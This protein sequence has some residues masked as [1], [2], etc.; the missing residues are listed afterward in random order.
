MPFAIIRLVDP[1]RYFGAIIEAVALLRTNWRIALMMARR[2]LTSRHANQVIGPFW[3]IGH[4]LFQ[5]LIF[6]FL[7]GVVFKQQLG[8]NFYDMPRDYTIYILSGLVA[9]LSILPVLT[10]SC[11]SVTS[12]AALVK[13]FKFELEIL[14]SKM[15]FRE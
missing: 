8:G 3:I 13:Q 2:D 6:V 5:M 9:W 4:P 15:S 14:R 7:F 1:I 10:T 11:V 12:N